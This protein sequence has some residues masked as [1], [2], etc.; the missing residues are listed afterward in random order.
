M[1][2]GYFFIMVL[3]VFIF[4]G[5]PRLEAQNASSDAKAMPVVAQPQDAGNKI[6]PVTGDK[7]NAK[8]K[9]TYE[10]KGKIYNLCCPGC[11]EE[12]RNNPEKYVKIVEGEKENK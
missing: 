6:C 10:Y 3:C 4:A 9:V 11:I 12:F 2:R 1:K 5:N 8:T 7:I